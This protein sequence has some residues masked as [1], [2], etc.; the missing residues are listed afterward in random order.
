[1]YALHAVRLVDVLNQVDKVTTN[2]EE[3]IKVI[4]FLSAAYLF[5]KIFIPI[6]QNLL[7]E[8]ASGLLLVGIMIWWLFQKSK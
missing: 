8:G 6:I 5:L 2:F 1:M 4:G 3:I 7:V